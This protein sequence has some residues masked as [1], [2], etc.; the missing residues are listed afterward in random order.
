MNLVSFLIA[1]NNFADNKT[2]GCGEVSV[3]IKYEDSRLSRKLSILV[4]VLAFGIFRDV[5]CTVSPIRRENLD[6]YLY[7]FVDLGYRYVGYTFYDYHHSFT[8]LHFSTL[9]CLPI[10]HTHC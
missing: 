1:A 2:Y 3:M 7:S 10:F 4:F 9:L 6:L 5:L 8:G